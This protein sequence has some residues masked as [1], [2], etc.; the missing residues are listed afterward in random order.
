MIMRHLFNFVKAKIPKISPTELIALRSGNTSLDRSIL[1][2]KIEFPK[3]ETFINKFPESKLNELLS[4]YDGTRVYPNNNSNYW[5]DYLAKNKYFSF[6]IDE[7]Y[8]GIKLNTNEMSNMLTKIASVDPALGVVTMV[9]NSLG[10]G[11]LLIHYGTQ[12]QKNKYLPGLADGTYIPCFGLTGPN[13]GSD[14]TGT[15]D[16]GTVIKV[17]GKTMIK[18]KIN[19]RY[20]TLAPVANLMGIA[21]NLKDPSGLLENKRS[22]ISLALLERGHK[23]LIQD[24]HHNPLNAGFPNGT[25]KGEFIIEL[26]Q[27]IGGQ[28]KI[29]EGWK[30]LMDCLSAGRGISLPATANASSKVATFG[31]IN[32]AKV[33]SQFNMPLSKME[34]IKEKINTMVFN[35]WI[36]QSSID[37]TN[38]ILD[39][40][41]S[42]AVL[43]AIMKQQTT[44][45]GRVVLNHGMDI[46]A[47]GA[48]CLGYSNFLEKFYRAAPIGITVE[49]SNTLTRSLIIFGQ[50]LNKSH[51]YIFPILESVLKNDES[52]FMQNF[53][54]IFGH[55]LKLYFSTFNFTNLIPFTSKVLENQLIDFACL[56]NFV[57]LKGGS[58]KREQMLSGAMADI[59]S[60]LYLALSVQYYHNNY[61]ASIKLTDYIINKLLNENQNKINEVINNLGSERIL[62]KHLINPVYNI[63]Y[64]EENKIFEEIMN[65]PNIINE[66]KKNI[67]VENNILADLERAGSGKLDLNS[68]EYKS[69][70]NRIINVDEFNNI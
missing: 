65:N 15:I 23:G 24:T 38:D 35:T 7:S 44:E 54:A 62:L 59:F 33:R 28:E 56:T 16:E 12:E 39:N 10:P 20:I 55:S 34:A 70:K 63:S 41:N 11:E 53:R 58:L 14:A 52:V 37:L 21:F 5:I 8:G 57:A 67:Y 26:D 18:I 69:L 4:S 43:S 2:G 60:N 17:N 30:M 50:G 13:N 22:G 47:G 32:Y 46:Q 66:I 51:P 9:P 19:K 25:I 3:K 64:E 48:I 42:P 6:L 1:M 36:I 45:R 27:I 31:I 49:G 29:G 40:G 68:E 61:K